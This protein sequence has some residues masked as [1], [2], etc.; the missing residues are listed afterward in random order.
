MEFLNPYAV[1][2]IQ[3]L[4]L[5]INLAIGLLMALIWAFVVSKSTRLVVDVRQ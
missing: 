5:I 1:A 4:E 2:D 3:I